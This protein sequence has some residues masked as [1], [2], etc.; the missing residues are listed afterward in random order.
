L[1][2]SN[3]QLRK[4]VDERKRTEN[5]LRESEELFRASFDLFPY[6]C[7]LT[8][9][10]G[11]YLHVNE[12]FCRAYNISKSEA[13]KRSVRTIGIAHVS[14]SLEFLRDEL[15]KNGLLDSVE[16]AVEM[17]DGRKQ[18]LLLSSRKINVR[19]ETQLLSVGVDITDRKHVEEAL[20]ESEE[21]YRSLF[22]AASDAVLIMEGNCII[23]CNASAIEVF[24][25]E[26][27]DIVGRTPF[28]FSPETQPSGVASSTLGQEHV[29]K[30]IA[31]EAMHFEWK[32]T[33]MDGVQFDA[34][35]GLTAVEV[36]GKPHLLAIVHDI[37]E[38]KRIE[39]SLRDSE[40]RLHA[41]FDGVGAGILVANSETGTI[42]YANPTAAALIGMPREGLVGLRS[43]DI[44]RPSGDRTSPVGDRGEEDSLSEREI[45]AADG[46]EI[47]VLR[48][49]SRTVIGG[50]EQLVE[51]FIDLTE[52]KKAEADRLELE[53]QFRQAQKMEAVGQLAGGV[54]H[55]F[56]NLLQA[57]IGYGEIIK[58]EAGES[59]RFATELEE[60][61]KAARRAAV[62]VR[63]LL[64]FSRRQML[65]LT[66]VNLGE[67]ID[68]LA[69]MIRRVIGEHITLTV[70]SREQIPNVRADKGQ[71]E[72]VLMNLCVNSRDAMPEG[73]EI[74]VETQRVSFDEDD[75]RTY[76]WAKP[77]DYIVLSVTD[78][79]AGMDE[80]TQA[81]IFEPF[82]TTKGEGRGTG[83][84]L[85]TVY[86]IVR[87]HN[88]MI[89]AHSEVGVGTTFRVYLPVSGKSDILA[90][91]K[92]TAVRGGVETIL[93]AEDE[94]NVRR[95]AQRLLE[96]AGY[97]VIA[98]ANGEEALR[99]FEKHSDVIQLLLLDVVM[100]GLGGRAV[101]ERIHA[102]HP[103]IR[104]L[105]AS[106][107]S[108]G[109][110]DSNFVLDEG[111]QLIQKPFHRTDLLARIRQV[112]D[113]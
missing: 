6:G 33:R 73:G 85:A 93:L 87:Q 106:G 45:L 77:G 25:C 39:D 44:S 31:G 68:S 43:Q 48:N 84:G 32:H 90:P 80:A 14:P 50:Q 55:D 63:Q 26:R 111:M 83:L 8:T 24:G 59:G 15:A 109:V 19:G 10:D 51:S 72:Q 52:L 69:K 104:A 35:V 42:T 113:A 11:K 89:T 71:I 79:G 103:G 57:I 30:A 18:N 92:A 107:Y 65:E 76:A 53:A 47:P 56:N 49:V 23:D 58:E 27:K 75:C 28:D 97:T 1:S 99:L 54:A 95:L 100:P 91:E 22:D 67:V 81:H 60:M 66:D 112:L 62:L 40:A 101:F 2:A 108:T 74:V 78:T 88:G 102:I 5:A 16:A 64:A 9:L 34:E 61:L 12:A 41:I 21:R 94:E 37:T 17:E 7:T 46:R 13:L 20:H 3:E 29:A 86:G 96:N 82:F 105:F 70:R 4:E 38:R 36:R 110:I 98:A